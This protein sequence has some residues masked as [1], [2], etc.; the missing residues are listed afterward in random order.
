MSEAVRPM[1]AIAPEVDLAPPEKDV[2]VSVVAPA[3]GATALALELVETK[4]APVQRPPAPIVTPRARGRYT[5]RNA[6]ADEHYAGTVSEGAVDPVRD[7]LAL[8]S[9]IPL[10]NAEQEVELAK[11]IEAGLF[12]D[13]LLVVLQE[14]CAEVV[15]E[16]DAFTGMATELVQAEY[17]QKKA[18]AKKNHEPL[19]ESPNDAAYATSASELQQHVEQLVGEDSVESFMDELTL[20]VADSEFAKKAFTEANLRLVVNIAR[21]YTS[22]ES[23]GMGLMDMIQE[24][25]AGLIHAVEKFDYHKGYKFSTYATWWIRQ[26]ITRALSDQSR[27]IRM[28]ANMVEEVGR[29]HKVSRQLEM[30]LER[31]P[32]YTEIAEKLGVEEDR[33]SMLLQAAQA[34]VSL[35][36][37]FGEAGAGQTTTELTDL[38]EADDAAP[39]PEDMAAFVLMSEELDRLLDTLRP[40]TAGM[41]RMYYGLQTGRPASLEEV[42]RAY[43]GVSRERVRQLIGKGME[44]LKDLPTAQ[45]MREY[46]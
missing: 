5:R 7:Y 23:K 24:G 3:V 31:D 27:T 8:I 29:M 12:A 10:I 25:N 36:V 13:R 6:G 34:P 39:G 33:V 41:I 42:G 32:T 30:E 28:P 16:A 40:R 15:P 18:R 9:Q 4:P 43:G 1:Y 46:L 19:P 17:A 21:R 45:G 14:A 2:D 35:N 44:K 37:E 22:R 26:A 11:R 38:L 20:L